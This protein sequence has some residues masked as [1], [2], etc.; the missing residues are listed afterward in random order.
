MTERGDVDPGRQGGTGKSR[1]AGKC[2]QDIFCDEN[3][4]IFNKQER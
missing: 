2:N 3:K 4:S 1:E